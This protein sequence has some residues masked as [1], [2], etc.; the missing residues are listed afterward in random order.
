MKG[1]VLK[2]ISI[3][4][5]GILSLTLSGCWDYQEIEN[6]GY[7]MGLSVD[8]A[9]DLKE[10][11]KQ[12]G[13][14][15]RD[16]EHMEVQEG[17]PKYAYT[18]NLPIFSKGQSQ[19]PEQGGGGEKKAWNLTMYGNSYFEVNRAFSTRLEYPPFYE[20]IQVY[21][22]SEA[23]ARDGIMEP[24]DM[25]LRDPEMRRRIK[26]F[27]TP[28]KAYKVFEVSP[29]LDESAALY[30]SKLPENAVKTARIVHKIDLGELAENLHSNRDFILP[31]IVSTK[32]E[33]QDAGAAVIK[34]G[35]MV[36]WLGEIDTIS[37]EWIKGT[38]KGG[39]IV[40][41]MPEGYE[42]SI[43]L[44]INNVKT[45]VKPIVSENEIKMIVNISAQVSISEQKR[46]GFEDTFTEDFINEI[47]EV[48]EKKMERQLADTIK[49][50]Q[51]K[52]GTDI[53]LF[54]QAMEIKEPDLWDEIK[55]KWRDIFPNIETEINV[56]IK[57]RQRGLIK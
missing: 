36:G 30:L 7:V 28:Q 49:F 10:E 56:E 41:N 35:R 24:L 29:K 54:D 4:L 42:G 6:R 37:A 14:N 31:R 53:F 44:E 43:T 12:K 55:D 47:E 20:H 34:H 48:A 16:I 19:Q 23:V 21:I 33:I 11:Y 50:V 27:V 2:Y 57:N 1:I 51:E 9:E 15:E 45:K 40:T 26:I 52:Y 3:M 13:L 46:S 39:V 38:I 17:K 25:L 22:M 8:K 32:N 18:I 5:I